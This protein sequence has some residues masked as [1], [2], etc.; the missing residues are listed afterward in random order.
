MIRWGYLLGKGNWTEEI[1]ALPHAIVSSLLLGF[2]L[3]FRRIKGF[4]TT[5]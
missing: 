2:F 4:Q 5:I 1:P 3:R